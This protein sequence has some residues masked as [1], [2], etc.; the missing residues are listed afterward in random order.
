MISLRNN[1]PLDPTPIRLLATRH[2]RLHALVDG[3]RS[4]A[5]RPAVA[6]HG[7]GVSHGLCD[8]SVMN[9]EGEGRPTTGHR[10]PIVYSP[11]GFL[12]RQEACSQTASDGQTQ[13]STR[14]TNEVLFCIPINISRLPHPFR[15]AQPLSLVTRKR[16]G[17]GNGPP[18]NTWSTRVTKSRMS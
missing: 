15:R 10:T 16:Y 11:P 9:S 12:S 7:Y 13:S 6:S 18:R 8:G 1:N 3:R 5:R 2:H 17:G 4:L 14:K